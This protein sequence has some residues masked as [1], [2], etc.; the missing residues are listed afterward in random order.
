M[1]A[2]AVKALKSPEVEKRLED[3]GAVPAPT[4]PEEFAAILKRDGEVW[5]KVIR[6]KNIRAD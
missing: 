2:E 3:L 6:E 1:N 4:S 5:G